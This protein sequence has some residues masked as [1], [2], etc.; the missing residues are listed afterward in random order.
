MKEIR[1]E[2]Q[3]A[4]IKTGITLKID[5]IYTED[6]T[7][8]AK[9]SMRK[10]VGRDEYGISKITGFTNQ[11]WKIANLKNDGIYRF[12]NFRISPYLDRQGVTHVD[13]VLTPQTVITELTKNDYL[14]NRHLFSTL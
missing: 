4:L 12:E 11:K 10:A 13:I 3:K 6:T 1:A 8:Y 5:N 14:Y 9:I 7:K 2:D